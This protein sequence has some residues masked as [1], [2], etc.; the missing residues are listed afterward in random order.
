[1]AF[2]ASNAQQ[3]DVTKK[4]LEDIQIKKQLLQKGV[5]TVPSN[6]SGSPAGLTIPQY[7]QATIQA[8]PGPSTDNSINATAKAVWNQAQSQSYGFFIPQDSLF[9]NSIIPVLPR[10]ENTPTSSS[11]STNTGGPNSGGK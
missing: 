8:Q 7:I 2:P 4:I 10:F 6:I 9:G 1:M 5:S 3:A 11:S